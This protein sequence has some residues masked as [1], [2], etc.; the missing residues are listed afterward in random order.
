[1]LKSR[2]GLWLTHH[3]P[4]PVRWE[5]TSANLNIAPGAEVNVKMPDSLSRPGTANEM[6]AE[7]RNSHAPV[8]LVT[9]GLLKVNFSDG[10]T[11]SDDQ[12]AQS[13]NFDNGRAEK[14]TGC[15]APTPEEIRARMQAKT[16]Q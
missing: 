14:E 7:A 4:L 10:S 8:V 1:M 5:T 12:A 6:A 2:H 13:N 11:W 16:T 9:I 3:L 15:H